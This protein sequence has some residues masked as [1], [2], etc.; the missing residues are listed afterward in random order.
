MKFCLV[1]ALITAS[2]F[3]DSQT[4][5]KTLGEI[6]GSVTDANGNPARG[7]TV[8]AV[9][10]DISFD[11]IAPRSTT[12]N[13]TG[14]FDFRGGFQLGSY[15]LYS[16]KDVEG[17]PDRS[18]IFYADPKLE[19]PKV[20]LT[21][22]QPSATVTVTL[23]EKAGGLAGHVFD[24]DTHTPLKAKLVFMDE[25]GNSYSVLVNGKYRALIPA[26][27]D[28]TLMVIVMSPDYGSQTPVP[29]LRLSSGQEMDM[30]IPLSKR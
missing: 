10:Q 12:T 28:V 16:R 13:G 11:N 1:F 29:P 17:Y 9:P 18:N 2:L 3:A 24:A 23:G 21:E 25:D 22:D 14:E 19:A 6:K 27:K 20:E 30:D 7:A 8:F 5:E 26:G 15:K 4:K